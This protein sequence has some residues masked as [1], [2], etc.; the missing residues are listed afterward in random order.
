MPELISK[1]RK[2]SKALTQMLAVVEYVKR[3]DAV[4]VRATRKGSYVKQIT[5]LFDGF[6]FDALEVYED[7]KFSGWIFQENDGVIDNAIAEGRD[8]TW[9]VSIERRLEKPAEHSPEVEHYTKQQALSFATHVLGTY[10]PGVK[11]SE[12]I[13]GLM[14]DMR[15]KE[16]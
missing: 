12:S 14:Y 6:A 9:E 2:A 13:M 11:I 3:G 15:R 1:K 7:D 16:G 4:R 8:F 5:P 10:A